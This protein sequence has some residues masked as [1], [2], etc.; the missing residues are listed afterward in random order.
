MLHIE[1]FTRRMRKVH[2]WH[3]PTKSRYRQKT[4]WVNSFLY[5]KGRKRFLSSTFQ[6]FKSQVD[7]FTVPVIAMTQIYGINLDDD[8][9]RRNAKEQVEKKF[10][11]PLYEYSFL[12]TVCRCL[13]QRQVLVNLMLRFMAQHS[14]FWQICIAKQVIIRTR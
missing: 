3:F 13:L 14:I 11:K 8:V 7:N 5:G 1:N 9:N 12:S 4:C 10:R 6:T 2:F